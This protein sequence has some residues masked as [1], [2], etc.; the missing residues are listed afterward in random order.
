MKTHAS[1]MADV[2]EDDLHESYFFFT[3]S[4]LLCVKRSCLSQAGLQ[5]Q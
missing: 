1:I 2:R 3:L 5:E 4:L